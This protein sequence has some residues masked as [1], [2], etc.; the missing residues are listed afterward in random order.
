MDPTPWIALVVAIGT[1]L[2]NVIQ[3]FHNTM[4]E[5]AKPLKPCPYNHGNGNNTSPPKE[6]KISTN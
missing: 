2:V 1:A 5:T 3:S 4:R 6:V